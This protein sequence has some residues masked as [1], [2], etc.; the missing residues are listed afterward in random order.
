ML[1][2]L[3]LKYYQGKQYI[4]DIK[5]ASMKAQFRGFPVIKSDN[6]DVT[7]NKIKSTNP[8]F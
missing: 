5:N 2:T 1:E 4:P 8:F 3:K 7:V 6:L